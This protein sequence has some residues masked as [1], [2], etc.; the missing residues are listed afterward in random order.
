MSPVLVHGVD[1]HEVS[2]AEEE[3]G[4]VESNWLVALPSLGDDHLCLRGLGDS[5]LNHIRLDL[6]LRQRI[7][8]H[9]VI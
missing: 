6:T 9:L 7:D 3:D 5:D 8:Q 2:D 1:C 4:R